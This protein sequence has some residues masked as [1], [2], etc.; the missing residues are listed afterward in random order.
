MSD[1]RVKLEKGDLDHTLRLQMEGTG[2]ALAAIL[3][4]AT[5]GRCGF[6]LFM[7]EFGEGGWASYISNA[8]R[9]D[10]NAALREFLR[11]SEAG[12]KEE[13]VGGGH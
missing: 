1:E 9:A 12:G 13:I 4:E 5:G 8:T 10:M 2:R 7:F 3:S 11:E 6:V